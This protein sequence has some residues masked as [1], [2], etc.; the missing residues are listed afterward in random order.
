MLNHMRNIMNW[1]EDYVALLKKCWAKGVRTEEIAVALNELAAA[2]GDSQSVF[3]KNKVIGKA[4]GLKLPKHP[5]KPGGQTKVQLEAQGSRQY[6]SRATPAA[7]R[8]NN[9]PVARRI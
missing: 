5:K 8:W 2:R 3:N 4:H 1:H 9:A 6:K 7:R